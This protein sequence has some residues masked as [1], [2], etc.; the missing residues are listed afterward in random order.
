MVKEGSSLIDPVLLQ[1][2]NINYTNFILLDSSNSS[3][4]LFLEVQ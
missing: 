2:E 4:L 1:E 3:K